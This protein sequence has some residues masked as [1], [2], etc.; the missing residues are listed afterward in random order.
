MPTKREHFLLRVNRGE[1]LFSYFDHLSELKVFS[2]ILAD[3][4][5]KL[6]WVHNEKTRRRV[7]KTIVIKSVKINEFQQE[8]KYLSEISFKKHL[9]SLVNKN[10]LIKEARGL[11]SIN[12][13]YLT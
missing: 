13:N 9:S 2:G 10:I 1:T 4:D 7:C 8:Y 11:Y 12:E 6:K 5:N 3:S